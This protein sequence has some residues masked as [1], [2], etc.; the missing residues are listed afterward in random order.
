MNEFKEPFTRA[1]LHKLVDKPSQY[2][3]GPDIVAMHTV[4]DTVYDEREELLEQNIA[5]STKLRWLPVKDKPIPK[6]PH[7]VLCAWVDPF[8]GKSYDV[9]VHRTTG[10]WFDNCEGDDM[11][12]ES[13][14]DYWQE[15]EPLGIQLKEQ[16]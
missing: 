14:P 3:N 8:F 15:I 12:V 9:L 2:R 11:R 1:D 16:P 7:Y 10:G 13:L 6:E 5:L 4:I